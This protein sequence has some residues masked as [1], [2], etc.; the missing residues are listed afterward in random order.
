MTKQERGRLAYDMLRAARH[1]AAPYPQESALADVQE[2]TAAMLGLPYPVALPAS[3][4]K[5]LIKA[6]GELAVLLR[7]YDWA[8][9]ETNDVDR[10]YDAVARTYAVGDIRVAEV[11]HVG[12]RRMAEGFD[13]LGKLILPNASAEG[14]ASEL[15]TRAVEGE[16]RLESAVKV[17]KYLLHAGPLLVL[18][19]VTKM[20]GEAE[21]A[22]NLRRLQKCVRG[23]TETWPHSVAPELPDLTGPSESTDAPAPTLLEIRAVQ[24]PR[25]KR[26][27][28]G[29]G[30]FR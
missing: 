1:A 7:A 22:W 20:L 12:E 9:H 10:T 23:I 5:E 15:I 26:G 17:G 14:W 29:I 4:R 25:R 19:D 13:A 18:D 28:G 3:G 11:E 24:R 8:A 30:G 16:K 21:H 6:A 27:L 2:H